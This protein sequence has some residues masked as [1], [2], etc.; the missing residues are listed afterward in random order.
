MLRFFII[1]FAYYDSLLPAG[2]DEITKRLLM[3]FVIPNV[4]IKKGENS[5]FF[6]E[7]KSSHIYIVITGVKTPKGIATN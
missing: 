4:G 7:G 2:S 1:F 3:W 6:G 5:H